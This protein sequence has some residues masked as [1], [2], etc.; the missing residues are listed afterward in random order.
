M[1]PSADLLRRFVVANPPSQRIDAFPVA[2]LRHS[3][4]VGGMGDEPIDQDRAF[5]AEHDP[6]VLAAVADVERGLGLCGVMHGLLACSHRC[7][8]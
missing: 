1:R 7:A 4:Q 5:L 8:M 3:E 6:D 2:A